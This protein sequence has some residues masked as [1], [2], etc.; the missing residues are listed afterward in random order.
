MLSSWQQ[1]QQA[2]SHHNDVAGDTHLR[3]N[4]YWSSPPEGHF[5]CNLDGAVFAAQLQVEYGVILR[6]SLGNFITG[7][8]A[9]FNGLFSPMVVES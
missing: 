8:T 6:D 3:G 7:L 9:T 5:K 1:Q 4:L 2:H